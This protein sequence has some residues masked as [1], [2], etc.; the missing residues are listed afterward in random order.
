MR[1]DLN[2]NVL[3]IGREKR[4]EERKDLIEDK[5]DLLFSN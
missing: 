2:E 1:G 3:I 4:E 5:D